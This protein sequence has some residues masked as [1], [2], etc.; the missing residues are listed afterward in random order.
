MSVDDTKFFVLSRTC[1][2]CFLIWLV[3]KTLPE[4][5]LPSREPCWSKV[6]H[7]SFF[8][9]LSQDSLTGSTRYND[10]LRFINLSQPKP[11]AR[12]ACICM[13]QSA[14]SMESKSELLSQVYVVFHVPSRC[15]LSTNA[16]HANTS[17]V[18][19]NLIVATSGP[20][21]PQSTRPT[22]LLTLCLT[23]IQWYSIMTS[24]SH[25]ATKWGSFG[26]EGGAQS[27]ISSFSTAISRWWDIS[28]ELSNYLENGL[29]M[30]VELFSTSQ[31]KHF[32]SVK[33]TTLI[34]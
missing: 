34:L 15:C 23:V 30:W 13:S 20:S 29:L 22:P 17:Y 25:S 2:H 5:L 16:C 3:R 24:S 14:N 31:V 9:I 4:P 33:L 12:P 11:S 19:D 8:R 1:Y 10:A 27:R 28:R 18:F 26:A 7:K 32:L 21:R 6:Y